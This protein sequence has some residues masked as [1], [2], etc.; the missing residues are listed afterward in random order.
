MPKEHKNSIAEG[1]GDSEVSLSD[2]TP[3]YR[4]TK[5]VYGKNPASVRKIYA[6][7]DSLADLPSPLAPWFQEFLF[8]QLEKEDLLIY[9]DS[10]G[11]F[12]TTAGVYTHLNSNYRFKL[13][14]SAKDYADETCLIVIDTL[15][16][17][18]NLYSIQYV[19]IHEG[20]HY[21]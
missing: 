6:A 1:T 2:K 15:A 21:L 20:I 9:A 13:G 7:L 18:I 17:Q 16:A 19:L 8:K 11:S 12:K 5:G 10:L 14:S 3:R 4:F